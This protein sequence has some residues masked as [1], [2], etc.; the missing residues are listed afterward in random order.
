VSTY[1][2][3]SAS[4]RWWIHLRECEVCCIA[5]T[6]D[7]ARLDRFCAIGSVLRDASIAA[8]REASESWGDTA[9]GKGDSRSSGS[10]LGQTYVSR[11]HV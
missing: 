3:L 1:P 8:Y 9:L 6:L 7:E 10:N 4:E 5:D 11:H 2:T